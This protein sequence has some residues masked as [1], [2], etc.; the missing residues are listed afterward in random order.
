MIFVR[1]KCRFIIAGVGLILICSSDCQFARI[2]IIPKRRLRR[3]IVNQTAFQRRQC[4]NFLAFNFPRNLNRILRTVLPTEISCRRERDVMNSGFRRG[5]FAA[6]QTFKFKAEPICPSRK[7]LLAVVSQSPF[8]LRQKF[9]HIKFF[10][11]GNAAVLNFSFGE[12]KN[13]SQK[14]HLNKIFSS[15]AKKIIRYKVRLVG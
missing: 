10:F 3:I 11:R 13:S 2:V 7:L 15:F 8:L 12:F 6:Y 1:R 5:L 9:N 14:N 4:R